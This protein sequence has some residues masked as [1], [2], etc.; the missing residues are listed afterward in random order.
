MKTQ[1]E[2]FSISDGTF[3][4]DNPRQDVTAR[5]EHVN[6]DATHVASDALSL[7]MDATSGGQ[8]L[9]L[10]ANAASLSDLAAGMPTSL[11]AEVRAAGFSDRP[12]QV[13][14]KIRLADG[15]L[16][17]GD[18]GANAFGGRISGSATV[19]WNAVQPAVAARLAA[20]HLTLAGFDFDSTGAM[21]LKQLRLFDAA[22]DLSAD[23]L[24]FANMSATNLRSKATLA[25]G[26]LRLSLQNADAYRGRARGELMFDASRQGPK[27]S[28]SFELARADVQPLLADAVESD[29]LSGQLQFKLDLKAAGTS[30]HD[31]AATASGTASLAFQNGAF[32]GLELPPLVRA[33][34]P[35]LPSAWRE[36][37]RKI[38]VDSLTAT[39]RVANGRAETADLHLTSPVAD[40]SGKGQIDLVNH[41]LDLRF[42]PKIIADG[43]GANQSSPLDLGAGILIRGPWNDPQVTADL[44]ALM[45]DP[46]G[47]LGKLQTLGQGLMAPDANGGK[48]A[49]G[50]PDL[51]KM[52]VDSIMKGLGDLLGGLGEGRQVGRIDPG[53]R[54]QNRAG[55]SR[56]WTLERRF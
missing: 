14:S 4:L 28:L 34:V 42:D 37:S 10:D 6:L 49:P 48:N 33:V 40:V 55:S 22:V 41:Q 30:P 2:A 39:F 25:D 26:T 18:I 3:I 44:S 43:R 31:M 19:D 35:Y 50:V 47:T 27:Q 38:T 23:S 20:D 32:T 54:N 36:Q 52:P 29:A 9:H 1:I 15:A 45:Q 8:S 51:S 46:Q 24:R 17:F 11:K 12:V 5:L 56:N 13:I 7:M 53:Q 21:D 16:R